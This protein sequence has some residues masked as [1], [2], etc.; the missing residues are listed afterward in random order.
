[1][2]EVISFISK[3]MLP[4]ILAFIP[5]YAI[6]R[7]VPIYESFIEGAKEGFPTAISIIPHLVGMMVAVAIFRDTGALQFYLQFLTPLISWLHIP[8]EVLPIG[9]LRPISGAGSLAFVESILRNYG[10]DSFLGKLASTIQGSTD[11][12]L[13]V[14]TVYFGAVGIRNSLYALKVGLWA[15]LAGFLAAWLI[16][17]M[18][19]SA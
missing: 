8:S 12:T 9:M 1:M 15:D 7:K 13:Y 10:P 18:V 4:A 14:I 6:F 16:C 19:F 5:L 3:M 2:Y 11:T 17:S